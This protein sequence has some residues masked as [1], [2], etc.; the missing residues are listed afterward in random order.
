M[1]YVITSSAIIDAGGLRIPGRPRGSPV[2]YTGFASHFVVLYGRPSRSPWYPATQLDVL[3]MTYYNMP[4]RNVFPTSWRVA[5]MPLY[6]Y[7]CSDCKSKFELLV[8]HQ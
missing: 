2:Q 8:S 7:Y 4:V 1:P 3:S 5:F 6:E